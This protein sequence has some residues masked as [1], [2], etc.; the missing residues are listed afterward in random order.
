MRHRQTKRFLPLLTLLMTPH[1]GNCSTKKQGIQRKLEDTS[2]AFVLPN[3]FSG[4]QDCVDDLYASD[5]NDDLALSEEEYIF[6]IAI[7][8]DGAISVDRYT[9]LPLSLISNFVYGACFCSI[10]TMSP[11]CCVGSEATIDLNLE[12]SQFIADN[13]I[14]L[15]QTVEEAIQMEIGS[16]APIATLAPTEPPAPTTS[17]TMVTPVEPSSPPTI[18]PPSNS[19]TVEGSR[20]PSASPTLSPTIVNSTEP[21]TSP[22]TTPAFIPTASPTNGTTSEPTSSP[23]SVAAP[24]LVPT[25]TPT[26]ATFAPSAEPSAVES[27]SKSIGD[28]TSTA[29]DDFF[30]SGRGPSLVPLISHT[31]LCISANAGSAYMRQFPI[32][33]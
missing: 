2:P 28:T 9:D 20:E 5:L 4:L 31:L 17:P 26:I 12:D 21:S 15:C 18:L 30:C 24:T 1:L 22:S 11:N 19:P 8:S 6:F 25:A 13:L 27:P 16:S 7:L 10:I 29:E 14:T 32:R 33:R 23:S 3:Q